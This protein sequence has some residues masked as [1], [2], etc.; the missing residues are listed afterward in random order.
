[1]LSETLHA[2]FCLPRHPRKQL[3]VVGLTLPHRKGRE[4][5]GKPRAARDHT[6]GLLQRRGRHLSH[7]RCLLPAGPSPRAPTTNILL[8]ARPSQDLFTHIYSI[9]GKRGVLTRAK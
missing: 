1:E 6:G 3:G 8:V 9:D 2:G 5:A 4:F 7:R